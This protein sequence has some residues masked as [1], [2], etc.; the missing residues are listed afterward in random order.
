M[1]QIDRLKNGGIL[2]LAAAFLLAGATATPA[3]AK[4]KWEVSLTIKVSGG[5]K[6]KPQAARQFEANLVQELNRSSRSMDVAKLTSLAAQ[7]IEAFESDPANRLALRGARPQQQAGGVNGSIEIKIVIGTKIKLSPADTAFLRSLERQLATQM[8]R[9]K[10]SQQDLP[11]AAEQAM[12]EYAAK[13]SG[14]P[15]WHKQKPAVT[16]SIGLTIKF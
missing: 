14:G 10:L 7:R 9:G 12:T 8:E 13:Q 4:P 11:G 15:Q 1:N 6:N 5:Q 16:F 3:A 2:F